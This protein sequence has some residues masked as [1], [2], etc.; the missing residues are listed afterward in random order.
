MDRELERFKSDINLAD[1]ATACGY[2]IDAK[3]SSKACYVMRHSDGDKIIIVTDATDDQWLF[4]SARTQAGGSILD[5]VMHQQGVNLDHAHRALKG[6][7][8]KP[9][10][11]PNDC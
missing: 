8:P 6:C 11:L 1:F 2:R 9:P 3:K 5:F 10:K 4:F 7:K